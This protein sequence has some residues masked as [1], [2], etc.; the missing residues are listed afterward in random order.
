MKNPLLHNSYTAGILAVVLSEIITAA[1]VFCVLWGFH[2]PPA[3]YARWFAVALVPPI[4]LLRYYAKTEGFPDTLKA[5]ITTFFIT[6]V[7]FFWFM[8]KYRYLTFS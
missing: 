5:V 3:E 1:L 4:F 2:L 8:I 7:A 6:G